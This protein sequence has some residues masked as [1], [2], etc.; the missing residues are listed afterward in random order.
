MVPTS[1]HLEKAGLE[2]RTAH[3]VDLRQEI[4]SLNAKGIWGDGGHQVGSYKLRG[5]SVNE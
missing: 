5:F 2:A 3:P 4:G 1:S